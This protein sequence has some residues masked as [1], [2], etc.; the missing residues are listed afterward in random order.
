[1]TASN[2]EYMIARK[3]VN[4]ALSVE[5]SSENMYNASIVPSPAE[6]ILL[7]TNMSTKDDDDDDEDEDE[8]EDDD[9]EKLIKL[10][11]VDDKEIHQ[12]PPSK[13]CKIDFE[14]VIMGQMV[15]DL[16]I[17]LA[18]SLLK[19]Q[20]D[21]L[22]GLN[23]TLYQAQRVTRT[24]TTVANKIQIIHCKEHHWIVATTVNCAP[25]NI[26]VYDSVFSSVDHETREV[27]YNLFQV[28]R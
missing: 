17:N 14:A 16:H 24:E 20:F 27:I 6:P 26:K 23:N 22:N 5:L 3:L 21:K 18:Q 25:G 15:T 13:R 28:R 10:E 9:D 1:M 8:D 2:T 7:V 4:D 19:R 11:N 12:S